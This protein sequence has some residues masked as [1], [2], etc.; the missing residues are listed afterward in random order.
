MALRL[1]R[2]VV[3][4]F[5]VLAAGTMA[6]LR[7][8][9]PL[10][11][12]SARRIRMVALFRAAD[13]RSVS[14]E[15]AGG[16]VV[17]LWGATRLDLRRAEPAGPGARLDVVSVFGATEITVPDTWRVDVTGPV[18]FG[19]QV[20]EVA[21]P[22]GLGTEAPRLEIRARTVFAATDVTARPVLRAAS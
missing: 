12:P 20:V 22:A 15:F 10:E 19:R 1:L 9:P 3:L 5:L 4:T 14:K 7:R 11:D 8:F 6:V 21:D 13:L 2:R 18:A 16:T 17:S